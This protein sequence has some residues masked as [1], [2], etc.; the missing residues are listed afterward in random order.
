MIKYLYF[1]DT[2]INRQSP[3]QCRFR[4]LRPSIAKVLERWVDD[5]HLANEIAWCAWSVWKVFVT[6]PPTTWHTSTL[7]S[8]HG[9]CCI[10]MENTC[11]SVRLSESKVHFGK[12]RGVRSCNYVVGASKIRIKVVSASWDAHQRCGWS[13]KMP[14]MDLEMTKIWYGRWFNVFVFTSKNLRIFGKIIYFHCNLTI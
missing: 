6:P 5:F 13:D 1:V 10:R 3:K 8:I 12:N 4:I 14:Q 9:K 11:S 7:F 2:N